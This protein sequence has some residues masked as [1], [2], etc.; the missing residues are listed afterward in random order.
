[1]KQSSVTKEL[2]ACGIVAVIRG[3]DEET[4]FCLAQSIAK[5]GIRGLEVT[6]TVPN[7]EKVIERLIAANLP[8]A[9]VG[10]GSVMDIASCEKAIKAGARFI[11]APN[12]DEEILACCLKN[13]IPYYPG[14]F[15]PTEIAR[16]YHKGAEL[17]KLFPGSALG[18]GYV[19][20]VHGPLPDVPLMPTG[21]V[22][23]DNLEQWV[24][25]GVVAVGV[26]SCLTNAAKNGD[27]DALTTLSRQYVE[28]IQK[29]RNEK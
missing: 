21:G 12:F 25:A 8:G 15:T 6:F 26:G 16:A 20:A 3:K 14:C 9:I 10:A 7:A 23:L 28:K 2:I 5:G 29:A 11:V 19:K 13:Q 27:Y 18:P 1:M 24:K 17:V 4:A 22:D